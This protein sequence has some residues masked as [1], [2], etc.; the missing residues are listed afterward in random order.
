V[1]VFKMASG[2]TSQAVDA[3]IEAGKQASASIT[4]LNDAF[5]AAYKQSLSGYD[6]LSRQALSCRSVEDI[7]AFQGNA[8]QKLQ[9][10]MQAMTK[11]YGLFANVFTRATKP[12]ALSVSSNIEP[13]QDATA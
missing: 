9:D 6:E 7:L 3:Y 13:K 8:L 10:H 1:G 4:E 5:T 11:V 2:A 12:I